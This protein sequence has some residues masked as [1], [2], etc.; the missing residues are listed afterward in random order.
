MTLA[1]GLINEIERMGG[2]DVWLL[3]R[4]DAVG[5]SYRRAEKV[6]RHAVALPFG[7]PNE[8]TM[9]VLLDLADQDF[10]SSTS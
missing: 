6:V 7:H 2:H 9:A 1:N 8:G 4:P 10:E 5:I 3:V